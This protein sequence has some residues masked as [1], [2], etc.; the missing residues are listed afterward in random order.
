MGAKMKTEAEMLKELE[1]FDTPTITN[2]VATYPG[3]RENCLGLYHPWEGAWYTDE[4]L[5]C[6]YPELGPKAGFAVTCVMG[7]PDPAF[8]RLSMADLLRALDASDKPTVVIIKQDLPKRIKKF[9]GLSGGN[10]TTAFKRLGPVGC[11]SDGPSRDIDE[12]R[13][14][15]FQYM[16]TGVCAGHGPY[17]V[18]AV[19]VPVEVCGMRVAPGDAVHMDSSGA[20]K[21]PRERLQIVLE[22]AGKLASA[23]SEKQAA[24]RAANGVEEVIRAFSG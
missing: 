16:L 14:M 24:M 21:F 23:E 7:L 4:L 15:E 5:K 13:P 6:I 11:I 22:L 20:V 17:Q 3:D 9:S 8:N 18:R 1:G 12:I 19:N 10:M 2:V